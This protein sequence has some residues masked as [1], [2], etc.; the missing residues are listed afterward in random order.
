MA[1][2]V[3]FRFIERVETEDDF[4]ARCIKVENVLVVVGVLAPSR[5]SRAGLSGDAPRLRLL[6]HGLGPC[7]LMKQSFYMF[8]CEMVDA[9]RNLKIV[10][11]QVDKIS[12]LKAHQNKSMPTFLFYLNGQLLQTIEGPQLPKIRATIQEHACQG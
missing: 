5:A 6:Q 1:R 3:D 2:K 12:S 8:V 4:Q 9:G 10:Q 7:E 11:A